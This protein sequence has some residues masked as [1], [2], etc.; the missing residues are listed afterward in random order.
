MRTLGHLKNG[1][2]TGNMAIKQNNNSGFTLVEML[3]A[4][5]VFAIVMVIAVD[6]FVLVLRTPLQQVDTQHVQEELNY[7]FEQVAQTARV[8]QIDYDAYKIL[9]PSGFPDPL[10]DDAGLYFK[11]ATTTTHI[12]LSSGQIVES[13]D[14]GAAVPLTTSGSSDVV[15]TRMVVYVYPGHDPADTSSI[16]N[17]Q[18]T[19]VLYLEGRSTAD[20]S[21][22]VSAQTMITLRYYA[23]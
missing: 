4:A 20:P 5:A 2:I 9:Y 6:L 17:S 16:V 7:V 22:P 18:E 23:R 11:T 21:H 14:G 3:V 15:I 12:Y 10:P 19:V 1:Y 13:V 8:N